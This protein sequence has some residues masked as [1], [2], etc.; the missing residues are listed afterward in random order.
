MRPDAARGAEPSE[1]PVYLLGG[2]DGKRRAIVELSRHA[3]RSS[4]FSDVSLT[5]VAA[6]LGRTRAFI[7]WYFDSKRAVLLAVLEGEPDREGACREFGLN[8]AEI[9]RVFEEPDNDNGE[10]DE[11][12]VEDAHG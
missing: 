9:R 2:Y 1:A 5:R 8:D 4:G 3:F 10:E 7:N 6:A 11:R 12:D